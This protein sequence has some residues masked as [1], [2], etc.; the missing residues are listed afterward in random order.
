[1]RSDAINSEAA[2]PKLPTNRTYRGHG[3]TD[4]NDPTRTYSPARSGELDHWTKVQLSRRLLAPI[5]SPT[6][7]GA[8]AR[9][10]YDV[11]QVRTTI[12]ESQWR[13]VMGRVSS[14]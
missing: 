11:F 12:Y 8:A 6:L 1:M 7:S 2:F 9:L 13:N 3:E 14:W 10:P 4:A 5:V